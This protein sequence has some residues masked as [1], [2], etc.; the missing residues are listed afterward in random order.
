MR[1][2]RTAPSRTAGPQRYR[3]TAVLALAACGS[4]AVAPARAQVPPVGAGTPA[5]ATTTGAGPG[6]GAATDGG[7]TA[8]ATSPAGPGDG[9]PAAA[10]QGPVTPNPTNARLG[11]APTGISVW[12]P[13]LRESVAQ[14]LGLGAPP[15][16]GWQVTPEIGVQEIYTDNVLQTPTDHRADY[17]TQMIPGVRVNADTQR[18]QLNGF[19]D[20]ILQYFA[21]T[22]SQNDIAQQLNAQALF[23]AVP[24]L[25]FLDIRGYATQQPSF[26][27]YAPSG[28][29]NI[30]SIT[31]IQETSFTVAPY[32]LHRFGSVGTAEIGYAY[33]VT[34]QTGN[35]TLLPSSLGGTPV[36]ATSPLLPTFQSGLL[37][38]QEEHA[39]F[40]TG[41]MLGRLQ[42]RTLLDAVQYGGDLESGYNNLATETLSYAVTRRLAVAATG[43]YE[44]ISFNGTPSV[45][46]SDAVWRIGASLAAG[47]DRSLTIAY[48]HQYGFNAPEVALDYAVTPR[49]KLVVRYTEALTSTVQDLQN[50]VANSSVD[51]YGNSIDPLTQAPLLTTNSFFAIN[52]NLVRQRTASATLMHQRDRDT[53]LLSFLDESQ[54]LVATRGVAGYAQSGYSASATWAHEL[55]PLWTS[56]ATVQYGELTTTGAFSEKQGIFTVDVAL[57]RALSETTTLTFEYWLTNATDTLPINRLVQNVFLV[58]LRRVFR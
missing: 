10:D 18:L 45:R 44:N 57:T 24:E 20:P 42:S 43:G 49:T 56:R 33:S 48:G 27:G 46:I 32:L 17:I 52:N 21:R 9:A 1:D 3:S 53:F 14:S 39:V 54:T 38:T 31:R 11:L 28:P 36:T 34:D 15:Q 2:A 6:A 26:G 35:T 51:A 50:F 40:T 47:P 30:N 55:T 7:S 5:A 16:P 29:L 25:L 23:T 22:P 4:L 13:D 12:L 41:Q 58:G 8:A 37:T 19:Y